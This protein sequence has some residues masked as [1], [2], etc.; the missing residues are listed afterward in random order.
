MCSTRCGPT[1][2]WIR[3]R[4]PRTRHSHDR[5][6]AEAMPE[7]GCTIGVDL[8]T[9]TAKVIAFDSGGR[10]LASAD[11]QV[12]LD[13]P[14]PGA[15]EQD[16]EAVYSAVMRLLGT[17]VRQVGSLGYTVERLGMSA[18]MHSLIPVAPD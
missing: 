12:E 11:A 14:E 4:L 10:E 13:R 6:E 7:S 16:P 17:V 5:Q 9:T 1:D 8:G 2:R 3:S 15:A 18:A